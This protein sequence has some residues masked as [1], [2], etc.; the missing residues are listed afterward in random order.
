MKDKTFSTYLLSPKS[1]N[2]SPKIQKPNPLR[3]NKKKSNTTMILVK[4]R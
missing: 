1:K 2:L 4:A 3:E